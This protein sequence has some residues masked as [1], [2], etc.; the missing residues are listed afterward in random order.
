M[1]EGMPTPHAHSPEWVS[2]PT[3]GLET[4]GESH[5]T[6]QLTRAWGSPL[7]RALVT[8]EGLT[9]ALTTALGMGNAVELDDYGLDLE[10]RQ[11]LEPV[12]KFL[13]EQYW[14]VSVEGADH[15]PPGPCIVVAN[16]SGALPFDGPILQE[17]VRRER[18]D[19]PEARWLLEDQIFHAPF[20]GTLANRLGAIRA[21]PENAIRLL[22]DGQKVIVFPEG[23]H[24]IGKPFRERY[25]LKRF[26][27]GG[28]AKLA[29]KQSVPII[30]AAVVGAEESMPLLF[31]LPG[32]FLGLPYLPVSPPPLP[33]RWTIRFGEA[34]VDGQEGDPQDLALIQRLTERT[35][36]SIDG[37]LTALRLERTSIW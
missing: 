25:Q 2:P 17:A 20:V 7:Q 6:P 29:L 34:V 30:P 16:H 18:P 23:I 4:L 14:R 5:A 35:R 11:A 26:G 33:N 24:G 8:A 31:K 9:R 10:L 12:L 21:S 32:K 22:D 1:D 27:R 19:G 15:L 36:E 28:F 13:F 37:M 3:D